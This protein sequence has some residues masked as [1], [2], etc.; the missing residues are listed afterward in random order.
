[1]A[2]GAPGKGT[3]WLAPP[4]HLFLLTWLSQEDYYIF[5]L[6]FTHFPHGPSAFKVSLWTS[7]LHTYPPPLSKCAAHTRVP[8]HNY[9]CRHAEA[10]LALVVCAIPPA[11]ASSGW[12]VLGSL[13][14]AILAVARE[15]LYCEHPWRSRHLC[16]GL[17][18]TSAQQTHQLR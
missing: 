11:K 6:S 15:H 14:T 12:M 8:Q 4:D 17:C 9:M 10:C 7:M 2:T 16:M 18:F 13:T 1:M 5:H 3:V